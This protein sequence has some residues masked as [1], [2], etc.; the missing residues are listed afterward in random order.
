LVIHKLG[1]K[2][3]KRKK[4]KLKRLEGGSQAK[5]HVHSSTKKDLHTREKECSK[6]G[7]GT[8]YSRTQEKKATATPGRKHW[9]FKEPE[10][11]NLEKGS[12]TQK[13]FFLKEKSENGPV[14]RGESL[15]RQAVARS[16][17]QKNQKKGS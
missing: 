9:G 7:G 6:E 13:P 2:T 8:R 12:P 17:A 4:R 14:R 16:V 1:E 11:K 5:S 10:R 15:L 3:L